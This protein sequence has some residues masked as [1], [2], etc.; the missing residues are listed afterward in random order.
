MKFEPW[1]GWAIAAVVGYFL[2]RAAKNAVSEAGGVL[3][4]VGDVL[5]GTPKEAETF[6][7]YGPIQPP[8][9]PKPVGLFVRWI[10]PVPGGTVSKHLWARS[11]PA[12]LELENATDRTLSGLLE[13]SVD[14]SAAT[15]TDT[16]TTTAGPY[17]LQ[18]GERRIVQLGIN[19]EAFAGS[20]ATAFVRLAGKYAIPAQP[21]TYFIQ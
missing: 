10:D 3:S 5:L 1:M 9:Q 14:E 13:I 11:Y 16:V 19:T 8:G 20:W 6:P 18:P 4:G 15:G 21:Q 7:T 2:V 17:T 12:S